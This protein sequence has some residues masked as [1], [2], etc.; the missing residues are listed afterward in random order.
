[1]DNTTV[2]LVDGAHRSDTP[3]TGTGASTPAND[4]T[5][6]GTLR[7]GQPIQFAPQVNANGS[8]VTSYQWD[9]GDGAT[10]TQ[11]QPS[12][13][14]TKGG[15]FLVTL[16]VGNACGLGAATGHTMCVQELAYIDITGFDGTNAPHV[17]TNIPG[18]GTTLPL[19]LYRGPNAHYESLGGQ[20]CGSYTT[21]E[22]IHC[23]R[24][25]GNDP[26]GGGETIGI[27]GQSFSTAALPVSSTECSA[28]FEMTL[29]APSWTQS[30]G[31]IVYASTGP[32]NHNLLGP[33]CCNQIFC[34]N[35][36]ASTHC[37][38]AGGDSHVEWG[39]QPQLAEQWMMVAEVKITWNCWYLCPTSEP[40]SHPMQVVNWPGR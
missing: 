31:P 40:Q 26:I 34:T 14:Y 38:Q 28:K 8:P 36:T 37:A 18:W 25:D 21:G 6:S 10:S 2:S 15:T 22:V 35:R 30:S 23:G 29:A 27:P 3:L 5:F 32:C 39:L 13:S 20:L 16:R 1:V 24:G 7:V 4:F 12:H 11:Q 19:V 17:T 33:I 9:F